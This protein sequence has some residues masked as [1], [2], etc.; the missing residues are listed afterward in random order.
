MVRRTPM[1]AKKRQEIEM[2]QL[3]REN[4]RWSRSFKTQARQPKERVRNPNSRRF[5]A[6]KICTLSS[7]SSS[8]VM[9]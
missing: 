5:E 1:T 8:R 3:N 9:G 7:R 4:Q 6:G 2:A